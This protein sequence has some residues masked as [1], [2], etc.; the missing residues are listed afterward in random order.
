MNNAIN[1]TIGA[2]L[3][4]TFGSSLGHAKVQLGALDTKL[5][6]LSQQKHAFKGLETAEKNATNLRNRIT[7]TSES[8]QVL[9]LRLKNASDPKDQQQIQAALTKQINQRD[10]L[11]TQ[12]EKETALIRQQ[13]TTLG[14]LVGEREKINT[15][16]EKTLAK[17]TRLNELNSQKESVG[18][19]QSVI[20]GQLM[21]VAA[22]G[23]TLSLP[24]KTAADFE[25]SISKLG[26]ITRASTA[27]MQTL[28]DTALKLGSSTRFSAS[29]ASEAMTFLGMAGFDT[30]KILQATPG[31]LDLAAASGSDLGRTADIA[32]NILSGMG[33]TADQMDRVGDVLANTFTSSNTTLEMLGETMKYVAPNAAGL[34]V[35][36][37]EVAALSGKL[38]DVGIQGSMAGTALRSAFIRLA[39]P[40]KMASDALN[41]LGVSVTDENGNFIGMTAT[42]KKLN[43]AMSDL[44]DTEK[45]GA[46]TK[47][48]G[49]EAA[50]AMS[51]LTKQAGTGALDA[52]IAK[53]NQSQGRAADM[54]KQMNNTASG[55]FTSFKSAMEGLAITFGKVLL[56]KVTQFTLALGEGVRKVTAFMQEN[57]TLVKTVIAVGGALVA[58]KLGMLTA[59]YGI[60]AAKGAMIALNIAMTANPIGLL[61]KGFAMLAIGLAAAW[62]HLRE[63]SDA[64][65]EFA[66]KVEWA[67]SDAW[68]TVKTV[69]DSIG[70]VF[71]AG[72]AFLGGVFG[73]IRNSLAS[74]SDQIGA[75]LE[76]VK[77]VV[78]ALG[79]T[80]SW[81]AEMVGTAF[82]WLGQFIGPVSTTRDELGSLA[83]TGMTVGDVIGR[84]IA[85]AIEVVTLP[86]RV[87]TGLIGGVIDLFNILSSLSP[88]DAISTKFSEFK[89]LF[90][91]VITDF[92]GLGGDIVS[93]LVAGITDKFSLATDMIGNLGSSIVSGFKSVL[94]IK[95]PSRVMMAAG[96]D[97]AEGVRL[98]I[99]QTEPKAVAQMSGL[100]KAVGAAFLAT[101][102]SLAP[103]QAAASYDT[104]APQAFKLGDLRATAGYNTQAPQAFK[105][106]DLR[107]TASY[108]T[109][110]PQAFK[111]GDLRAT[112]G[113]NTQAPQALAL[114]SIVGKGSSNQSL[115]QT[116]VINQTYTITINQQPNQD[117]HDLAKQVMA[118]I[119]RQQSQRRMRALGDWN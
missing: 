21:G 16:L 118:E 65:W 23:A 115:A 86:F 43:T 117:A 68:Q 90:S 83:E 75:A 20:R 113:Y 22:L 33:L 39:A 106:G 80:F 26:S 14:S 107:A 73:G 52:Y 62:P 28:S 88:F 96:Q 101:S 17:Q 103:L 77:M 104:Q 29:E 55:A 99:S 72:A 69:W 7:Q 3:G 57:Q 13:K 76:P 110:A 100:G 59:S 67:L 27:E 40:P 91:S 32:S 54:A 10:R 85:G 49:T 108:D 89:T 82:S 15:Q 87:L 6:Q 64:F 25:Q 61:I 12:L 37:E 84:G 111:L 19:G 97:T 9:K 24:I 94:G 41:E 53:L 8:V 112:A 50:S 46:I 79:T 4:S 109:Q 58:V 31:L 48:F 11:S 105:L 70:S 116:P 47:I 66:V 74:Q 38:G 51:E 81:L 44:S 30:N 56:P 45:L 1:F 5:K 95:S 34:G 63:G 71:T 42:L 102:A 36:L 98:G 114:E 119:E 2:A 92:A 35:S 60:L 18:Q 78:S 93:G